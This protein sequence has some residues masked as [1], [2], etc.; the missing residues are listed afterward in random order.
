MFFKILHN[1]LPML[2]IS[3]SLINSMYTD[4]VADFYHLFIIFLVFLNTESIGHYNRNRVKSV[5]CI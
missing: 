4:S 5:I 2:E 1:V 3:F